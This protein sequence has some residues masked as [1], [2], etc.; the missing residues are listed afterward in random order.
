MFSKLEDTYFKVNKS[1]R[2]KDKLI[3]L[4]RPLIM[5]I[6]NVTPDSFYAASRTNDISS[7]LK[8][9]EK[10]V[11]DGMDILDIGAYS[12]RPGADEVKE[13]DELERLIPYIEVVSKEFPDLMISVDTFRS[14]VAREAVQ[15]GAGI[16]NDIS[17]FQIDPEIVSVAG[18]LN[19]P[20]ILMHMRGTPQTMQ[21]LTDY[22]NLFNDGYKYFS[23]KI[24][25]LKNAGVNDIILDPGFGFS[26]TLEQNFELLNEIDQ[27]DGLDCPILVGISRKS[28]IYKKLGTSPEEALN[29]TTILNT[30]STIKGASILRVHDVCEASEIINLLY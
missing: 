24:T 17:G 3:Q 9:T 30:L 15:A 25:S 19:T 11:A 1:I 29:G 7:F 8:K 14:K 26:K 27:F 4:E 23:V 22:D 18:E 10:Q 28:M 21:Q 13:S 2:Y 20:Y 5:G 6:V 16:I 12:S